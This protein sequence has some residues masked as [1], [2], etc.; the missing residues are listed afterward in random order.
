MKSLNPSN[1]NFNSIPSPTPL[2]TFI[3]DM[4]RSMETL[5]LLT[6]VKIAIISSVFVMAATAAVASQALPECDEWC[7]DVQIPYPFGTR[8]GCYLNE[9]FFIEC[10]T[11]HYDS[12]KAFLT[13]GNVNVTNISISGELQILNLMAQDC[14]PPK[15]GADVFS[16]IFLHIPGY[17]IS[18][19][20]NKFIAIGCDTLGFISGQ[21]KEDQSF[22]TACVALCDDISSVKDGACSGNGCCQLEIPSGLNYLE[23]Q[24]SS[25]SNHTNVSSFNPCGYAFVIEQHNFNFSSNYIRNFPQNRISAVLDWAITNTTCV[26]AKNK[27]NCI[28]GPNSTKVDLLDDKS[29]YLCRCLEGFEG[30]P[31]LPQG[32]QGKTFTISRLL[33][34]VF[35]F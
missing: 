14:Y 12:P 3:Q 2:E 25:L 28:C 22:T 33:K 32:C 26:T 4:G 10:N 29:Q 16:S 6:V 13:G 30:N 24:V 15:I 21:S 8:E 20:K 23:I 27:T 5:I 11:T 35:N 9:T 7:G 31:Y 34:Q 19:T 18:S 17:T 1:S